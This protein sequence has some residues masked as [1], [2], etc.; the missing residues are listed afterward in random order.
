MRRQGEIGPGTFQIDCLSGE[1]IQAIGIQNQ[2][3]TSIRDGF[4]NRLLRFIM[5]R[6]AWADGE[7]TLSLY[8]AF[9]AAMLKAAKR[10][11]SCLGRR[12]WLRHHFRCLTCDH[13]ENRFGSRNCHQTCSG[14]Q[15][16]P[17]R[18]HSSATLANRARD[19]QRMPVIAFVSFRFARRRETL[20]FVGLAPAKVRFSYFLYQFGR[21][22]DLSDG[23]VT[24]V[25]RGT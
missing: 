23:N 2:R 8:D 25:A 7:N 22:S 21:S 4:A 20:E 10:D 14:A 13:W 19:D 15:R 17:R 9:E 18:E 11:G 3:D 24:D 5:R 1:R 6:K 16:R 12:Q